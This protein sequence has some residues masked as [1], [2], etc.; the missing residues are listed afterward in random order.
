MP[1]S[2]IPRGNQP[3][4]TPVRV[5]LIPHLG[6][7]MRR[8]PLDVFH[9]RIGPR[10]YL[11]VDPLQ[12]VARRCASLTERH[13]VRVVDVAAAVRLGLQEIAA[14]FEL[15]RRGG[16]IPLHAHD[17]SLSGYLPALISLW[18]LSTTLAW[19]SR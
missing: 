6:G 11:V 9:Q 19:S 7:K 16:D 3:Q 14:D 18:M 10:K 1:G 2:P 15:A 13:H 17:Q 4:H 5:R 8:H 12:N